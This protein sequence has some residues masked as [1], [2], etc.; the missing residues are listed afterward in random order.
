[1]FGE[2]IFRVTRNLSLITKLRYD[3]WKNLAGHTT[4]TS[5][6]NPGQIAATEFPDR[7]E[8]AFSSQISV[9]YQATSRFSYFASAYR[10]FRAPT[11]NELYR[12]FRV[13]DVLTLANENLKAERLIGAEAGV[14]FSADR[15]NIEVRTI[16]FWS[17]VDRAVANRTL[18][19]TPNLITRQRQNLGRTRSRGVEVDLDYRPHPKFALTG[20]YLLVD[21]AVTEFP[22]NPEL[23]GRTIPQIARHQFTFQ[24]R[25]TDPALFDIALQGRGSSKQ[26]DDDLN[27]LPLDPYFTLDALAS[28]RITRNFEVFAAFENLLNQRFEVGRTPVTTVGPPLTF[29]AGVRLR[30]GAR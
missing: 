11:L 13:G 24:A 9:L 5:L 28:R 20:G 1:V 3:H 29:R 18:S 12:G 26:F 2:D 23:V 16:F 8:S 17:E 6:L 4:T 15:P 7:T 25:Y 27:L 30:L 14:N 19:V 10:A 22:D 21:A